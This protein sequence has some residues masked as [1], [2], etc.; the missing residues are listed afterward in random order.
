MRR[1][2][3]RRVGTVVCAAGWEKHRFVGPERSHH[4]RSQ[5]R[6]TLAL[7]GCVPGKVYAWQPDGQGGRTIASQGERRRSP[8]RSSKT[9]LCS[10]ATAAASTPRTIRSSWAASTPTGEPLRSSPAGDTLE[11]VIAGLATHKVVG[12]SRG[13]NSIEH[14][15]GNYSTDVNLAPGCADQPVGSG[16]GILVLGRSKTG[17]G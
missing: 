14:A 13:W 11:D 6:R 16:R 7:S 2:T 4:G 9:P 12:P 17:G 15:T 8:R 10:I 5:I 3:R 1:A